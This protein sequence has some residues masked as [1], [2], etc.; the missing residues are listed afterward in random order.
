VSA[1]DLRQLV[2]SYQVSQAVHVA[3]VLGLA[4]LVAGGPRT[5]DDL[6]AA[7]DTDADALYRLLRA[8]AS[9]G[10][11]RE[12]DGKRFELAEL[13]RPLRSDVPDSLADWA[14]FVGRRYYR[15]AWSSLLDSVRTGE[16]AF[17]LT[18]GV[19][20]W[21]YRAEHPDEAAAF[22]RAMAA[23]SRVIV[24]SLLAAYD[25]GRYGTIVD[26]GGGNGALLAALL[27]ANPGSRGILFDQPH[28]VQGVDLGE[29][30]D[31]V[32]GSFFES[33]PE[34]GD[35]YLLKWI[36]HDWEDAEAIAIL[37]TIRRRGA[38]VL[39]IERDLGPPNEAPEAKLSDLNMLV[40]PGGRERTV[41]EFA[42]LLAAADYE[43]VADVPTA[44][45]M[46][47]LEA[48]PIPV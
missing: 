27:E 26:V 43:L 16:N 39:V 48:A 46:H 11:F 19:G 4:D 47:V 24:R 5:S 17:R 44:S 10:V 31:I 12:R 22:D 9:V 13:G 20:V 37:R 45:G 7:T 42:L 36:L 35:A 28:V 1:A 6:A 40:A 2:N 34:G 25:F 38:P 8:L 41:A 18:H 33:V 30:C 32:A 15:D 21:E 14:V 23:N 3:A 29:R